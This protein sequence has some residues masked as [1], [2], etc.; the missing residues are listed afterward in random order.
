[1]K[2]STL[3]F[4][5]RRQHRKARHPANRQA[6]RRARR[7][8]AA[9]QPSRG[10]AVLYELLKTIQHCFPDLVERL[11]QVEAWRQKSASTLVDILLAG[12]MLFVLQQGARNALKNQREEEKFRKHYWRLFK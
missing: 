9:T 2:N 1:M 6:Q 3:V 12:I 5:Q 4:L 8:A 10:Q 11:R 7:R